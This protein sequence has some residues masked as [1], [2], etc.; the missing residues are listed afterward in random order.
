MR[1]L[2]ISVLVALALPLLVGGSAAAQ[3]DRGWLGAA[4]Q[5][6]ERLR[7]LGVDAKIQVWAG[8]RHV[9]QGLMNGELMRRIEAY[10]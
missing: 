10:R 9:I 5:A 3:Q 8:E 6:H 7:E 4:E 2:H 1:S